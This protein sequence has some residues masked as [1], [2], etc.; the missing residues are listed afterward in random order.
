M[1]TLE[2]VWD[3][4]HTY[5]FWSWSTEHVHQTARVVRRLKGHVYAAHIGPR[6]MEPEQLI[7]LKIARGEELPELE[8]EVE[9]YDNELRGLQGSVVPRCFGS[10][11]GK[12]DGID[13]ACLLMEFCSGP[14][15]RDP[16]E[17]KYA[18]IVLVISFRADRI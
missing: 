12:V 6:G 9:F 14:P 3:R 18:P 8:R 10:F 15:V 5:T 17:F 1:A 2:L 13:V 16:H 11:K 4:Q 7:A